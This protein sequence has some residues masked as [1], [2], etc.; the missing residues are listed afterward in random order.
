M[1][2]CADRQANGLA[3]DGRRVMV[4]GTSS[5]H[6]PSQE[7]HMVPASLSSEGESSLPIDLLLLS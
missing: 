2:V 7:A 6:L 3:A 1:A 5:Y 4:C